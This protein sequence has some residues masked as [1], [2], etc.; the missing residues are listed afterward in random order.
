MVLPMG[1]FFYSI[2][3]DSLVPLYLLAYPLLPKPCR[4]KKAL[5]SLFS[6]SNL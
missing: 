6:F 1:F 2:Y 3:C 5:Y 4:G